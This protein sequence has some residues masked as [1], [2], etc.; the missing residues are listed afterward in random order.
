MVDT[1]RADPAPR[2]SDIAPPWVG[3]PTPASSASL[4]ELKESEP[5][6]VS[7]ATQASSPVPDVQRDDA[8]APDAI[9]VEDRYTQERAIP[10]PPAHPVA[11]VLERLAAQVRSG[12]LHVPP[13]A[14]T[15]DAAALAAVLTALLRQSH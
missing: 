13:G 1:M 6:T 14:E 3:R 12:D 11:A 4:E 2:R 10:M 15:N 7:P 5:W 8:P 9:A